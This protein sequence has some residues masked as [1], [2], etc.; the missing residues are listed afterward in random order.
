MPQRIQVGG[1]TTSALNV[2][3]GL[4]AIAI[5]VG[6]VLALTVEF[7]FIVV[8]VIGV[9]LCVP[10]EIYAAAM[11]RKR[12]WIEDLGVGF[13][14]TRGNEDLPFRDEQVEGVAIKVAIDHSQMNLAK[15][16]R[17]VQL[18]M[19]GS[20]QRLQLHTSLEAGA[21]DPLGDLLHRLNKKLIERQQL[22]LD[23]GGTVSGDGWQLTRTTL[24]MGP[25][26]REQQ[27]PLTNVASVD[28]FDNHTC[29][30]RVGE[31]QAAA[32]V[33]YEG[34]NNYALPALV[35]PL[36]PTRQAE[37]KAID[38]TSLGRILFERKHSIV[39]S[40]TIVIVLFAMGCAAVI[41]GFEPLGFALAGLILLIIAVVGAAAIGASIGRLKCHERGV[42]QSSAFG[43]RSLRYDQ[44]E[45]F[46]FSAIRQYVNGGYTGT[47]LNLA[48]DP[49]PSSGAK[50][51]T[52]NTSVKGEDG[53]L[54]A[55]RDHI[56]RVIAARMSREFAAGQSVAWTDSI[57]FLPT[58]IQYVP[59]GMFGKKAPALI[60]FEEY[61]GFNMDQGV[62]Y[63]FQKGK[64]KSVHSEKTSAVNFFPGFY[65]LL[66]ILHSEDSAEQQPATE[67]AE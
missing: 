27:F 47:T 46:T 35:A 22:T 41:A 7:G 31:E 62:F 56:A 4:V 17:D 19:E 38:E 39:A 15:T 36:L 66:A 42:Q 2:A 1:Q 54:D 64:A 18:W 8:P 21:L 33:R 11:R 26:G 49:L 45:R 5:G 52:Y 53:D 50:R 57:T 34:R 67:N 59:S 40:V 3:R 12:A 13:G 44:V 28:V 55:L 23:K 14:Y 32:K 63:L 10:L 25:P 61:G 65:L 48:F 51:I 24:T 43:T 60:S 30:W 29:V 58:G 6:I 37:A 20:P 9:L 16:V